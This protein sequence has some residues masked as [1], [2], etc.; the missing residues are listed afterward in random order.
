VVVLAPSQGWKLALGAVFLAAILLSAC[1]RAPRRA[2]AGSDLRRLVVAALVLYAAGVF[3]ASR[4]Y[5]ILSALAYATG[6]S[7]CTLAAWLSRGIDSED[8]PGG[9]DDREWPQGPPSDPGD[10]PWLDW[11]AFEREFRSYSERRRDPAVPR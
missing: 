7:V 1:A 11:D 9:A 8:P 3:A 2:V 5:P 6:I 4:H 10:V